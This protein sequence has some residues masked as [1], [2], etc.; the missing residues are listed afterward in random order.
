MLR[1]TAVDQVT[2]N[3][4]RILLDICLGSQLRILNG[5][6]IGDTIGKPTY[7]GYNG[8]SI[9]DYCICSADFIIQSSRLS[10]IYFTFGIHFLGQVYIIRIIAL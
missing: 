6:T 2:M 10:I 4:A 1:N 5:R 3:M 9:D 7:H 8:S